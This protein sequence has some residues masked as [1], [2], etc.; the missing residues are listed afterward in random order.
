MSGRV[1]RCCRA[2]SVAC[3]MLVSS[4]E[5]GWGSDAINFKVPCI[6]YVALDMH[7][8]LYVYICLC[9]NALICLFFSCS[10]LTRIYHCVNKF[11]K[12][13]WCSYIFTHG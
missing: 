7:G 4:T 5:L 3:T 11:Q 9:V 12:Y 8:N 6:Y 2:G 10:V 1:R 13:N